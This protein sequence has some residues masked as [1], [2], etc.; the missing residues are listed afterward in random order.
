MEH[1]CLAVIPESGE[2]T[3]AAVSGILT[4]DSA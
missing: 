3:A 4:W 1:V 2:A